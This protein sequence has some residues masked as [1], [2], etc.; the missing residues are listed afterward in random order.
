MFISCK[1]KKSAYFEFANVA[2]LFVPRLHNVGFVES[3]SLK[4]YVSVGNS[5]S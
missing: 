1:K 3:T 2:I 4:G 5:S